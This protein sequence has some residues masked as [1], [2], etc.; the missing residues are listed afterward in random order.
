MSSPNIDINCEFS[1]PEQIHNNLMFCK[2]IVEH[3]VLLDTKLR[4]HP[5]DKNVIA[6][7]HQQ[8]LLQLNTTLFL[9]SCIRNH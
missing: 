1:F 6:R 2:Q 9:N 4:K 5:D 8:L 3:L 7:E